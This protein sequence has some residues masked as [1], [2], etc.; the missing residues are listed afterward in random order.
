M[1]GTLESNE[2]A[3]QFLFHWDEGHFF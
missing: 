1:I 3:F 2:T